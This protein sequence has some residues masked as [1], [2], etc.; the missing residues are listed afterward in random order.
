[1]YSFFF[2][3][4]QK[5]DNS[6]FSPA[7]NRYPLRSKSRGSSRSEEININNELST[8]ETEPSPNKRPKLE[9]PTLGIIYLILCTLLK[10]K[11]YNFNIYRYVFKSK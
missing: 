7:E 11:Y 9:L 8:Q 6:T 5:V 1:M 3:G 10:H 2:I 4:K